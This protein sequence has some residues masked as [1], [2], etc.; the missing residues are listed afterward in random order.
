MSQECHKSVTRVSQAM[1][2][3]KVLFNYLTFRVCDPQIHL[4]FHLNSPQVPLF[5]SGNLFD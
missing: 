2:F 4:K 5:W 1:L 3:G